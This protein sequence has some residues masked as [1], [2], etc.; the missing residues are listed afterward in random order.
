MALLN[1]PNVNTIWA[2]RGDTSA[3]SE[4]KIARGW[5]VEIPPHQQMNWWMRRADAFMAHANQRGIPAWDANTQY[6]NK[7]SLVAGVGNGVIYRAIQDSLGANPEST[8]GSWQEAFMTRQDA[9]TKTEIDQFRVT[10]KQYADT[11]FLRIDRAFAD[12]TDKPRAR[13]NLQVLSVAEGDLKYLQVANNLSEI[14][15]TA[16]AR[17]KLAVFSKTEADDRFAARSANLS[18]LADKPAARTNLGLGNSAT[19]NVGSSGGTVAAGDDYRIVTA[20]PN[21]RNVRAGW[22]LIGGGNLQGDITI[23]MGTPRTLSTGT[24]NQTFADGSHSHA[25]SID[26]GGAFPTRWENVTGA[27]TNGGTYWNTTGKMMFVAVTS[28]STDWQSD[29][30]FTVNGEFIFQDGADHSGAWGH[31]GGMIMVPNGASYSVWCSIGV[32]RWMESR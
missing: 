6:Y 28:N 29:I 9:Y 4:L 1:K 23:S 27:R 30:K 7:L 2:D 16:A 20:T 25:V 10:D 22:G 24:G 31:T 11:S 12:L 18:D 17:L 21:T 5:V 26:V 19:L 13:Q 3:P 15:D 8:T 14:P 32:N